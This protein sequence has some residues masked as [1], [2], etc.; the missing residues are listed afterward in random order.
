MRREIIRKLR[1]YFFL[2]IEALESEHS[3]NFDRYFQREKEIL[4]HFTN[5]GLVVLDQHRLTVTEDGLHF[6]ELVS[7]VF[8]AY[9]NKRLLA[10]LDSRRV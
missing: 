6:A 10:V 4:S 8:D 5:D 3:L 7:S 1:T 2:D 9:T